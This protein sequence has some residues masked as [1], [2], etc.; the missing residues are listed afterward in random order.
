ME[1]L[2]TIPLDHE[3][4]MQYGWEMG[5]CGPPLCYIH[6]GLPLTA[7]EEEEWADGGDPC[8]HIVR[9]YEDHEHRLAIENNDGPTI[10][11]ASNRGWERG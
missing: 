1:D 10:W 5:F 4:W 2:G 8:L 7:D 11:R 6:D 9:L 3:A